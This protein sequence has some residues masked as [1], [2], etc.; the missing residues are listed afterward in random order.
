MT[1]LHNPHDALEHLLL[2]VA[3]HHTRQR[4]LR[5]AD[6][7]VRAAHE[8]LDGTANVVFET[9]YGPG[10]SARMR[11]VSLKLVPT[12]NGSFYELTSET[13]LPMPRPEQSRTGVS[14]TTRNPNAPVYKKHIEFLPS[15]KVLTYD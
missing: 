9:K 10:Y 11:F 3:D 2:A 7:I 5:R 15:G 13:F 12:D 6:E 4:L 14:V 8:M 1:T